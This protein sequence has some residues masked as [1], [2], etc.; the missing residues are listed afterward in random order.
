MR[1]LFGL[2]FIPNIFG[3]NLHLRQK[4]PCPAKIFHRGKRSNLEERRTVMGTKKP[5]EIRWLKYGAVFL[6]P[7][8]FQTLLR[9]NRDREQRRRGNGGNDPGT[10]SI[11]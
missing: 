1:L 7:I 3:N 2:L 11:G 8:G 5:D 9:G 6:L 10:E 4:Q